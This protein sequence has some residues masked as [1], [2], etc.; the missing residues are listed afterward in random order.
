MKN[1]VIFVENCIADAPMHLIKTIFTLLLVGIVTA[2]V[3]L[4]VEVVSADS[5]IEGNSVPVEQVTI[6]EDAD[7]FYADPGMCWGITWNGP[8]DWT[9]EVITGE[10]TVQRINNFVDYSEI[11]SCE[12]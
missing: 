7:F 1:L 12:A 11:I 3:V 5:D 8:K 9:V 2:L 10:Y 6:I 4:T